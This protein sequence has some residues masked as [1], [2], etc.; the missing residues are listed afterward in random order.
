MITCKAL[1]YNM[2]LLIITQASVSFLIFFFTLGRAVLGG[3]KVKELP[4]HF[5]DYAK[6]RGFN[7]KQVFL[8]P[9]MRYAGEN[10][11]AHPTR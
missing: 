11:Y 6:P 3:K 8:S 7:T 5:N 2:N 1:P 10:T 4:G 9:S